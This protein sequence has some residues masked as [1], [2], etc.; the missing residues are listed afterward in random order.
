MHVFRADG[1][2]VGLL[3]GDNQLAQLHRVFTD[4]K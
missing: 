4:G 2:A 3:E 1:A